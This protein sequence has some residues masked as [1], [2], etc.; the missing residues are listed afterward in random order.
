MPDNPEQDGGLSERLLSRSV[1]VGVVNVGWAQRQYARAADFVA[2]RFAVLGDLNA[3]YGT[4]DSR[5]PGTTAPLPVARGEYVNAESETPPSD[6]GNTPTGGGLESTPEVSAP[7]AS[8]GGGGG[9]AGGGSGP[10]LQRKSK[11]PGQAPAPPEKPAPL[12]SKESTSESTSTPTLM[13][14]AAESPSQSS[15]DVSAPV[16]APETTRA[17]VAEESG[18]DAP[19][20]SDGL[21]VARE[22]VQSVSVKHDAAIQPTFAHEHSRAEASTGAESATSIEQQGEQQGEQHA[23]PLAREEVTRVSHEPAATVMRAARVAESAPQI[24]RASLMEEEEDGPAKHAVENT[25]AAS[26]SA[27]GSEQLVARY[28]TESTNAHAAEVLTQPRLSAPEILRSPS[29]PLAA[30]MVL[31]KSAGGNTTAPA[32]PVGARAEMPYATP[33]QSSPS[34]AN[35]QT[36]YRTATSAPML[37]RLGPDEEGIAAPAPAAPQPQPGA[38]VLSLEQITEHVSRVLFTRIAVERER[39]GARRWL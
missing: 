32:P 25:L 22:V 20:V 8:G 9:D 31:R 24:Q 23:L 21:P 28:A 15:G 33:A 1:N 27:S 37:A 6:G 14:L 35:V 3:R 11:E 38:G 5:A 13:R 26:A 7:H 16:S 34:V 19:S 2:D 18:G 4:V 29:P 30:R 39:R 12:V 36:L 17:V 10:T